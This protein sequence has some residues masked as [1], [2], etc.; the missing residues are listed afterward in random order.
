MKKNTQK[1]LLS[2]YTK[3]G[4][5]KNRVPISTLQLIV[6]ELTDGG[7]RS[8]LHVLKKQKSITTQ[9]V[10]G[11]TTVS[12]THHGTVLLEKEFP[13]LNSKWDTWKGKWDCMVFLEAPH[14]DKQFRYLR[15][16][17]LSQGALSMSRGVYFAPGEFSGKVTTE[18][19]E[20]YFSNVLIFSVGEW[21]VATEFSF[22][23]DKY[24]L[25]DIVES[26]SGISRDVSRLIKS[27]GMEKGLIHKYKS[28]IYLV[29]D[30]VSEVLAEDPGFS[31]FYFSEAPNIKDILFQA[32]S[33]FKV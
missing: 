9:R 22:I 17:L 29:Y 23:I 33:I 6:P 7:F 14:F 27:V 28:E 12:I 2:L 16:L 32:N 5:I 19:Q 21:K 15:K 31:M 3:A 30:R 24:G 25:S 13:A 18:V 10:L 26:Y 11:T 1:I 8:L 20:S 4:E